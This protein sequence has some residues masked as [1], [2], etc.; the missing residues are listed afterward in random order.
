ERLSSQDREV[1]GFCK[2]YRSELTAEDSNRS[3]RAEAK[4]QVVLNTCRVGATLLIAFAGFLFNRVSPSDIFVILIP[5][6]WAVVL[7]AK[8]VFFSLRPLQ[9][10]RYNEA[11]SDFVFE[12]QAK[13]FTDTIRYDVAV[14]IWLFEANRQ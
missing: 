3:R 7:I 4:A 9:P 13:D 10:V 11:S 1:L 8:A 14:R 6:L 12:V 5:L 2:A